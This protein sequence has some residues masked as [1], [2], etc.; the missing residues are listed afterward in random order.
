MRRLQLR[1]ELGEFLAAVGADLSFEHGGA[2]IGQNV[3]HRGGGRRNLCCADFGRLAATRSDPENLARFRRAEERRRGKVEV[4]RQ[5]GPGFEQFRA[6]EANAVG[7]QPDVVCGR[8]HPARLAHHIDIAQ[9]NVARE[10]VVGA[11][12]FL[13][14]RNRG[15]SSGEIGAEPGDDRQARFAKQ[16]RR[17]CRGRIEPDRCTIHK[18]L[19]LPLLRRRRGLVICR[20]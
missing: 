2:Q 7:A 16:T 9:Q 11:A 17:R 3:R 4:F 10:M 1:G 19:H 13:G 6:D 15:A 14:Q 8:D 18:S 12:Q 5:V 20:I